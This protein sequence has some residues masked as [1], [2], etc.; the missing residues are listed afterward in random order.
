MKRLC[1]ITLLVVLLAF[2]VDVRADVAPPIFPP[3]S[4]PQPGSEVTQVRMVAE[5]VVIDV[6]K[7]TT[8]QGLGHARVTADF[9]MH[10]LGAA[11]ES[12][13]VRFPIS[14]NNGRG[15]YP[16]IGNL[17]ITVNNDRVQYRRASYPDIQ[18]WNNDENVPWAEFDVTFPSG[19]DVSIRV[20]YDLNGS[21]YYPFSAFYYI[22]E[23]GAGWKDTIG[24]ADVILRLPYGASPQN[25][26]MDLEIG[27]AT[28]TPGG[29]FQGNEVRWH[30]E[31]FEPGQDQPVQNIEFALVA[32]PA[33]QTV[34]T[35]QENVAKH[36]DD[37]EVWGMLAK[38]YKGALQMNKG[39]REDAG[40]QELYRLSTEAYEKC[41]SLKPEDAQWHAGFADLLADR[42]YWE[43]WTNGVTPETIRALNE[44]HTALE[45]APNDPIV[46]EIAQNISNMFRDG[47]SQ[48]GD[49]FDFP[50]LTQTPTSLPPTLE[51]VLADESTL[52]PIPVATDTA[53][54]T[55]VL[56]TP[57]QTNPTPAPQGSSPLCGSVAVVP[58]VFMI[59]FV[60]RKI[61]TVLLKT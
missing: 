27:W 28:T 54:A 53:R 58:L 33:W 39:Y 19:Q 35:A 5:A 30:F 1:F 7:D 44:I 22:L 32:P 40:G 55:P 45:L 48:N 56:A 2:P 47:M 4:N 59:W 51:I 36:P 37:G 31:N 38:A 60:R 43:M 34:V 61:K 15:E 3:G 52:T 13:A 8:P 6:R 11:D 16:E 49:I 41:L 26:I 12:M 46:R 14:G 9:T 20:A 17:L 23:T 42:A 10:N 29:I 21:G 57:V 24:S 18:Y 25:V 50:W